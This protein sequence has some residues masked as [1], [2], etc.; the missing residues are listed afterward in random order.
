MPKLY[1]FG[2]VL[3]DLFPSGAKPGGAPMNV[4]IHAQNLGLESAVISA[5]GDDDR[6]GTLL[7]ILQE[8]GVNTGIHHKSE[9]P[10]GTV[11]VDTSIL[12]RFATP[13]TSQVLGISLVRLKFHGSRAI[14]SCTGL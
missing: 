8:R 4:A 13:L 12:R 6:G 9:H 5:I 14:Y 7:D 2:E 1:C 11:T 3:W 10:T